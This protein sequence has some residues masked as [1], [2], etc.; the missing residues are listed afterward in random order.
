MVFQQPPERELVMNKN[1]GILKDSSGNPVTD[2]TGNPVAVAVPE[3]TGWTLGQTSE[4]Y[5]TGGRG[6]GTI[7]NYQNSGD[8]GGASYGAYQFASFLPEKM[9]NGKCRKNANRSPVKM[10]LSQSK[11]GSRFAGMEPATTQFDSTWKS[12]G[13]DANFKKD[14]HDYVKANYYDVYISSL[15]RNGLDLSKF[16]AAVHDCAWS[17]AVNYGANAVSVFLVPL[18]EKSQLSDKEI[19]TLVQDYKAQTVEKYF[20]SSSAAVQQ[21]I[22]QRA[23]AEKADLLKLVK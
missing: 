23:I 16:G 15:K 8:F 13:S 21:G 2:S 7:N 18:A 1:D 12:L 9:P 3:L 17:T 20:K 6:A 11:Y 22:K 19:V 5:E 4:K 10:F 14:Q